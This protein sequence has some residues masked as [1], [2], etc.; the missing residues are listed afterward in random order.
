MCNYNLVGKAVK[1]IYFL[2]HQV[3]FRSPI[4][5]LVFAFSFF[6]SFPMFQ[7]ITGPGLCFSCLLLFLLPARTIFFLHLVHLFS[8]SLLLQAAS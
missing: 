4:T 2:L 3:V 8:V 1:L 6:P 5:Y 7:Q